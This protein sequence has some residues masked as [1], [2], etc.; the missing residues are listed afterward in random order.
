ML[1]ESRSQRLWVA[2]EMLKAL[3]VACFHDFRKIWISLQC[4]KP[5]DPISILITHDSWK[6]NIKHIF[7][8]FLRGKKRKRTRA[9][10]MRCHSEKRV[11]ASGDD[12]HRG[13][14]ET[15]SRRAHP[16]RRYGIVTQWR[17][18]LMGSCHVICISQE[19]NLPIYSKFQ[20]APQTLFDWGSSRNAS[21]SN[22][23]NR[24]K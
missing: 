24:E 17:E 16:A 9:D 14:A 22:S 3:L 5:S 6:R 21:N 19:Q 23:V 2:S 7:Y 13:C 18:D 4:N 1:G 11:R 12:S 10:P 8:F 15:R 20:K